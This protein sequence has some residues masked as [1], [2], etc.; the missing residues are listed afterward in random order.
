MDMKITIITLF[1]Q[2]FEG[3]LQESIVKRAQ[4][5][6]AVDLSFV[7]LRDF[8]VDAHGT[9][10]EPPYGGG[11]GMVLRVE[12]V[13]QALTSCKTKDS[14]VV[15][16]SPRGTVYDQHKALEFSE[17]K[18][19]IIVAGH[20]EAVD[21]RVMSEIDEEISVGDYVLTGGELPAAIM[22]DSIVR[23][24]PGVL[25]KEDATTIESFFEVSLDDLIKAVGEDET[26]DILQ[27]T[28]AKTVKLLEYPHYTRPQEFD[29]KKVPEILL[30]GNHAEI[31][32]WQ[33]QEAY[34]ITK[35]R[36]PDLLI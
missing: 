6:G 22:V 5:K 26:L 28:G 33:L 15:L 24:L 31:I 23:L 10:D 27:K 7:Q 2:M 35:K 21:E 29:G 19:L 25:K 8:A 9:V 18:D 17:C 34:S 3:F 20:Y 36:R 4:E 13:M 1:P 16:T 12:P 14:H 30:S 32:K 11:A